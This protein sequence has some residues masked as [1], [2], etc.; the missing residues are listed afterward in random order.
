MDVFGLAATEDALYLGGM[1]SFEVD[2]GL[3]R[4]GARRYDGFLLRLEP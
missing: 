4:V 1:F 3:G 2:F